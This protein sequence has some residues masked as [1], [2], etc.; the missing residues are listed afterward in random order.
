MIFQPGTKAQ[1]RTKSIKY[2]LKF[3]KE[4]STGTADDSEQK[5]MMICT[6]ELL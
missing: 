4:F 5:K 2:V 3:I 6:H 1:L